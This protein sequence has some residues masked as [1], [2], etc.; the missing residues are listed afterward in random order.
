M[1]R[2]A[3]RRTAAS[4][5]NLVEAEEPA[6]K[7]VVWKCDYC[8]HGF[9]SERVFMNHR[10]KEMD[11]AQELKSVVGQAAYS[12]YAE[13]MSLS[14]RSV[15]PIT[16]FAASSLYSTFIKFANWVNRVRLPNVKAFIRTMVQNGNVQPSLWARD[17][18]YAMYMQTYDHAVPPTQQF[19]TSLDEILTLSM[20]LKCE[21]KDVFEKIGIDTLIDMVQRRKISPWFLVSSTAFRKWWKSLEQDE[22]GRVEDTIQVGALTIRIT[23]SE[24]LKQLLYEFSNATKEVGL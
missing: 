16:T 12:Y 24:K 7:K 20:E 14:K 8:D 3:L 19:I 23:H 1:D 9:Q 6:R 21:P 17:N 13:W 5:R 2:E 18:T 22:A 15:P 10:C 4:R 11:R